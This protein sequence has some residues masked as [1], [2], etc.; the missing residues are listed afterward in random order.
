MG[1]DVVMKGADSV[2]ATDER[3]AVSVVADDDEKETEAGGAD[4]DIS[5]IEEMEVE[6]Q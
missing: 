1:A 3:V 2:G 6:L 5:V 4:E